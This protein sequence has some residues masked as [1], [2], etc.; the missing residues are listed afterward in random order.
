MLQQR[1]DLMVVIGGFNSSNTTHLVEIASGR[2]PT[3][4]I[5]DA[6]GILSPRWIRHK[7][8]GDPDPVVEGGWLPSGEA[9][10]GVT[11]GAS[12][13]NSEIGRTI[14]KLLFLRGVPESF[15]AE[16]LG[17]EA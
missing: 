7:P 11:A 14:E 1:I 10:I 9:V 17:A 3:F 16:L 13:P 2:A 4:H 8:L 15:L 6:G 5:E 12:T